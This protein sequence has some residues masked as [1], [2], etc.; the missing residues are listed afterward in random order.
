MNQDPRQIAAYEAAKKLIGM[1]EVAGA[2][3]NPEIV[4]FFKDSG[5]PEIVDDETAWC[6]AF[7]GAMLARAGLKGTGKLNARSYLD[8]GEPV[9]MHEAKPGDIVIFQRGDS[10]WQGH[11]A[12]FDTAGKSKLTVLGG[13][14][15]N[16]V[17]RAA[18]D[19]S[20][21]LGIRRAP[22]AAAK[23]TTKPAVKPAARPAAQKPL[24]P[25]PL[26]NE[27]HGATLWG[28]IILLAILALVAFGR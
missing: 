24:Q 4:Q 5:H 25:A 3:H 11:V 16:S 2:K 17:S 14:Q 21:L 6:A 15:S 7:V 19:R 27:I 9:E 12:F 20:K 10:A 22:A 18:Y 1:K 26:P 23:P 8:W 13:N 28:V